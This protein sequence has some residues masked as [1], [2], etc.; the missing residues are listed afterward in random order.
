MSRRLASR[1]ADPRLHPAPRLGPCDAGA[2]AIELSLVLGAVVM[3]IFGVYHVGRALMARNEMNHALAD[4]VRDVHLRPSTQ[5]ADI[6]ATLQGL[7]AHYQDVD[8]QVE[9]TAIAGTGFMRI[10]VQFPYS[11]AVPLLQPRDVQ[12]RAE[13]LAPLVSPTLN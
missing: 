6:E 1:S 13:T 11:V 9:V 3:L 10:A 2:A 8:L 4:A 5:P 12:L 7:L